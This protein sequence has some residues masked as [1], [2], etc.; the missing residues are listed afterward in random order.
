MD[1][2]TK[3]RAI[4][5]ILSDFDL[6][7]K[8]FKEE[9][10][11]SSS[12]YSDPCLLNLGIELRNL[13]ITDLKIKLQQEI[14]GEKWHDITA[15]IQAESFENYELK[16]EDENDNQDNI[17][18]L[19]QRFSFMKDPQITLKERTKH[20]KLA[21]QEQLYIF[22]RFSKDGLSIRQLCS[23]YYISRTTIM[24]IFKNFEGKGLRWNKA[25][26]TTHRHLKASQKLIEEI[27]IFHKESNTPFV[28][29]DV[30]AFIRNKHKIVM[31]LHIIRDTMKNEL[32]LSY[33]KGKSRP[34]KL[35]PVKQCY[36]KSLFGIRII[37]KLN[38]FSTLINIDET[39]FSRATKSTHSW[40]LKG[41]EWSVNNI[42]Y[43]NSWSLITAI[44]STGSVYGA[45]YSNSVDAKIFVKFL[46]ELKCFI[47][48]KAKKDMR[49][50]LILLDNA[51]THHSKIV[52]DFIKNEKLN[53]AF[54]PAYWP[55]LAPIEKYFAL[56]KRMTIK[57]TSNDLVDWKKEKLI[58]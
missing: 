15:N 49:D 45:I 25:F 30:Q 21:Y 40:L 18:G 19:N 28:V 16:W 20:Q 1:R 23:E 27:E 4:F 13:S 58:E 22:S 14:F 35:D 55:E 11:N 54:I 47:Q 26:P 56:L 24:K 33:K 36:I 29:K 38:K 9:K 46:K 37:R 43:T 10:K 53:I 12:K 51:P 41:I 7:E 32:G 6:N 44:T 48:N 3:V 8:E 17:Y 52:K 57:E 2:E 34:F 42:W 31:P 39:L 5:A 50:C